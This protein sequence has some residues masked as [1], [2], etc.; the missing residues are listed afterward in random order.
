[1]GSAADGGGGVTRIASIRPEEMRSKLHAERITERPNAICPRVRQLWA[2]GYTA[3]QIAGMERKSLAD[4]RLMVAQ[5]PRQVR[6][7]Y[8]GNGK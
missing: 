5:M 4:V 6:T 2:Q 3:Q 7:G 1:M 8:V